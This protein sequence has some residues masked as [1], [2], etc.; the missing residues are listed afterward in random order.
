MWG[1]AD[2]NRG[3]HQKHHFSTSQH[4]AVVERVPPSESGMN[5]S[6]KSSAL[7]LFWTS[8]PLLL[9]DA[10]P[11][12]QFSSNLAECA[13]CESFPASFQLS[14]QVSLRWSLNSGGAQGPGHR[15]CHEAWLTQSWLPVETVWSNS[16]APG[17]QC[18]EAEGWKWLFRVCWRPSALNV[19]LSL[20]R[21]QGRFFQQVR[22]GYTIGHSVSLLSLTSAIVILC[23]LRYM[24]ED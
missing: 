16:D 14:I 17:Q 23:V 5:N 6:H 20:S 8:V 3:N 22:I 10:T 21:H 1:G 9:T 11:L 12:T 13:S 15:L 24:D 19:L 4:K 18:W 2:P 7:T